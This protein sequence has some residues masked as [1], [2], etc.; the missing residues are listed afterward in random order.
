MEEINKIVVN[1]EEGQ[2]L[3]S[4]DIHDQIR[5]IGKEIF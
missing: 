4:G 2:E 1:Q 5:L 3:H